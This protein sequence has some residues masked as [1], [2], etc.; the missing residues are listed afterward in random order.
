MRK[1]DISIHPKPLNSATAKVGST[2]MSALDAQLGLSKYTV[3]P[4]PCLLDPAP[5]KNSSM[6]PAWN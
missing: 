6:L 3:N 1:I 2:G 5:T 4:Y